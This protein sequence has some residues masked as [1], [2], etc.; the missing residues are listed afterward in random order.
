[1]REIISYNDT[2]DSY[3]KDNAKSFCLTVKRNHTNKTVQTDGKK[4]G[5]FWVLGQR[6]GMVR[7][8]GK[9]LDK[10]IS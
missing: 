6:C 7:K 4:I 1:M 9:S 3:N 2:Y 8:R 5:L 10:I